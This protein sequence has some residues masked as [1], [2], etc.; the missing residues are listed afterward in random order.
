[1][2]GGAASVRGVTLGEVGHLLHALAD[3]AAGTGRARGAAAAGAEVALGALVEAVGAAW[4]A[5]EGEESAEEAGAAS[6][7]SSGWGAGG[8]LSEGLSGVEG[9]AHLASALVRPQTRPPPPPAATRPRRPRSL[10][11]RACARARLLL[12]AHELRGAGAAGGKGARG[13][14]M[15]ATV[16]L[17][18]AQAE[19]LLWQRSSGERWS[20]AASLASNSSTSRLAP[21]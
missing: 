9:L 13:V 1:M 4:G 5:E 7:G 8:A 20:L 12:V 21:L 3:D 18:E 15:R 11:A 2:P 6:V 16:K 17:L 10:A 14:S 19:W